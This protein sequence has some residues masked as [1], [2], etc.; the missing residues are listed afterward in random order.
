MYLMKL[1]VILIGCNYSIFVFMK[2]NLEIKMTMHLNRR[3]LSNSSLEITNP[4]V[5]FNLSQNFVPTCIDLSM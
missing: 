5:Y 3:K 2:T 1:F 4:L